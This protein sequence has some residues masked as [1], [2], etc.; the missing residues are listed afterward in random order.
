MTRGGQQ[1]FAIAEQA[2]RELPNIVSKLDRIAH[3]LERLADHHEKG[4]DILASVVR[5]ARHG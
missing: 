1:F 4:A 2:L 5:P 3:A